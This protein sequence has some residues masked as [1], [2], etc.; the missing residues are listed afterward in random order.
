MVIRTD[1]IFVLKQRPTGAVRT[2][3]DGRTKFVTYL[4]EIGPCSTDR[5][6]RRY[7]YVFGMGCNKTEPVGS[8]AVV[9]DLQQLTAIE[10]KLLRLRN[11]S[12]AEEGR[13]IPTAFGPFFV[14][15]MWRPA[16]ALLSV[17]PSLIL[18]KPRP[19]G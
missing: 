3:S 4:A 1:S 17:A 9:G 19:V 8:T 7:A 15:F 13:F 12:F 11:R 10:E 5:P 14:G 6:N 16:D 18:A 2:G